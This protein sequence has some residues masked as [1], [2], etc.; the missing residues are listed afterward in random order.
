MLPVI[1]GLSVAIIAFLL[2]SPLLKFVSRELEQP[3][4]ILLHDNSASLKSLKAADEAYQK[5]LSQLRQRLG[6]KFDL[7]SYTFSE[8]LNDTFALD[9]SGKE[10]DISAAVEAVSNLYEN[11]NIGAIILAT[12]GIY[13]K[14]ISPVYARNKLK[15]PIFTLALGDTSVKRD[16]L[17]SKINH[18]QL[19]Y[20]NNL[21]P[22]EIVVQAKKLSGKRS[23][24]N[25]YHE[26]RLVGSK[27]VDID[28]DP[29]LI[30]FPFE[31][32]AEKT[33]L[34]RY[35]AKLEAIEGDAVRENNSMDFF[36]E[37]LDSRQKVLL[38]AETPD[39]DIGAIRMSLRNNPNYE[40][41]AM[42]ADQFQGTLKPYSLVIMHQ[43]PG[44][45]QAAQRLLS[46]I[47]SASVPVL[48]ISGPAS[49]TG[50]LNS[51]QQLVQ[52]NGA[53]G[54]INEAQPFLV[55]EFSLFTVSDALKKAFSSFDPLQVPYASYKISPGA[56][57]MFSQKIGA[58]ET[59]YPLLAFQTQAERKIALLL[60]TGIW[61]WRLHDYA[62]NQN[63]ERF[64]EFISKLV[65]YLCVRNDQRK[66]RVIADKAFFENEDVQL[67]AEVYNASYELVNQPD[68][69]IRIINSENKSFPFTFSKSGN[70]YRLNA[71]QFPAGEYRY[72][73]SVNVSGKTETAA[74]RFIIKPVVQEMI[75]TTAD[76]GLLRTI[77]G[78]SGGKLIY[79]SEMESLPGMIEKM[80]DMKPVS[81]SEIKLEDLISLRWIFFLVLALLS[82][83][84]G[85][86]KWQGSY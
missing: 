45:T 54:S 72:E 51:A 79:P 69:L 7:K 55:K 34:L 28:Q 86:R 75:Q 10:T 60:G 14:G 70:A 57:L 6:D 81:H 17:I 46:E 30:S 33:G 22:A 2:L 37:V 48:F 18:N 36:I 52:F 21:F 58:V 27:V 26:N 13:N 12:D 53:N 39:P 42:L 5:Q 24:L 23:T 80:A 83:E 61:R 41:E 38:L 65:Q 56:T 50:L 71:G 49:S 44:R 19:A 1:R 74:G 4:V 9:F 66:F 15:A 73:A 59:N 77:A 78:R 62:E 64:D 25:L 16:L 68:V 8:Q 82:L 20:L 32:K 11:R 47:E 76:H 3:L 84:W 67:E 35:T 31:L 43:L 29:F 63:H 85:L 40:V